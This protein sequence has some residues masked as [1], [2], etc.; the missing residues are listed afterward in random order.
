[1][2][3]FLAIMSILIALMALGD[4]S[5][6]GLVIALVFFLIAVFALSSDETNE[7]RADLRKAGFELVDSDGAGLSAR[8]KIGVTVKANGKLYACSAEDID[9]TWKIVDEKTCA[10][11][12]AP[13]EPAGITAEDLNN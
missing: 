13:K 5:N 9:G 1:M 12:A 11:K 8:N 4:D 6:G 3:I 2:M 10:E 7:L